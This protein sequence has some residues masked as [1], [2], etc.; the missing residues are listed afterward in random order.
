MQAIGHAAKGFISVNSLTSSICEPSYHWDP[1]L[2]ASQV[3]CGLSDA[4][5]C[6]T[7]YPRFLIFIYN[8]IHTSIE[9]PEESH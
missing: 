7:V 1:G 9:L 8:T 5:G 4:L 6:L 2:L 3:R